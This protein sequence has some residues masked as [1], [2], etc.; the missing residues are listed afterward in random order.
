M[1]RV[2]GMA[3]PFDELPDGQTFQHARRNYDR[4]DAGVVLDGLNQKPYAFGLK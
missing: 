2:A 4:V 3:K 1:G